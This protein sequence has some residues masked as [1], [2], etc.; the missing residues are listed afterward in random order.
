[1]ST[2]EFTAAGADMPL[3]AP[4]IRKSS[5]VS[6]NGASSDGDPHTARRKPLHRIAKVRE[7]QGMS[8]RSV[9]RAMG[10]DIRQLRLQEQASCDL[11]LSEVY[12]WQEALGVPVADL[13]VEPD[14]SLSR[15]VSER[16]K[17]VRIMKTAAAMLQKAPNPGMQRMAQMLVE[18]LVDIMPELE[19]VGPWHEF[20]Q[21]RSLQDYGQ[22]M[23]RR[24]S[25]DA[26][27]RG[28]SHD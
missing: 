27:W 12:K 20:G 28:D 4:S 17:M 25:E 8:L 21:R 26:I 2:I 1:M 15:P 19:Q 5:S 18:Q 10:A 24:I 3:V 22:V 11:R 9:A 7:E 23:E 16:A 14:S 13:L 6:S